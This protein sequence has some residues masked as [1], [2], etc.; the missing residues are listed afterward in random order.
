MYLFQNH[1]I[2]CSQDRTTLFT[3]IG[4]GFY[5]T[6]ALAVLCHAVWLSLWH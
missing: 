5:A 6:L 1:L 3:T 4:V 2:R